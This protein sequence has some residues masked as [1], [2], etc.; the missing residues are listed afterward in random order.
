MTRHRDESVPFSEVFGLPPTVSMKTAA[1]A[2][3]L[4]VKTAYKR[5]KRGEFPCRIR[6]EGRAYV[7]HTHDLM[8]GLGIQDVRVHDD[9]VE[10]GAR[11]ADATGGISP[12]GEPSGFVSSFA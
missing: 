6:K 4:S 8:R 11:L 9:D 5:V 10:M 3:N 7:I 12:F 1:R 2:L